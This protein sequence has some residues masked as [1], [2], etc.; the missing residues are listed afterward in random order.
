MWVYSFA[1]FELSVADFQR[2]IPDAYGI[3]VFCKWIEP[4]ELKQKVLPVS[5]QFMLDAPSRANVWQH[6][7]CS[8]FL[9]AFN[10]FVVF[11]IVDRGPLVFI[12]AFLVIALLMN[13]NLRNDLMYLRDLDEQNI[14]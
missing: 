11:A 5:W 13:K 9:I 8:L 1:P 14:L 3:A 7:G 6:L 2:T 4:A 12:G 10:S